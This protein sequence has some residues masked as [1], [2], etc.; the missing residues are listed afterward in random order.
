[1]PVTMRGAEREIT[2]ETTLSTIQITSPRYLSP[3][4]ALTIRALLE[5]I[6]EGHF[7]A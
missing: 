4:M 3:A 7:I 5:A 1:M 6:P 2:P